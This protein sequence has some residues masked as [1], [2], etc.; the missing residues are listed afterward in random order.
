MNLKEVYCF[1]KFKKH[2]DLFLDL[3]DQQCQNLHQFLELKKIDIKVL[4]IDWFFTLGFSKI[5]LEI[6]ST[7]IKN[8][9]AEGWF[10]FYA[11]LIAFLKK[12]CNKTNPMNDV[13]EDIDGFILLSKIKNFHKQP[14]FPWLE[15]MEEAKL[16]E[17]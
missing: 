3:I 11:F 2:S 17:F 4:I 10:F 7:F 16:F 8:L 5:P 13:N 6:S 9:I 15:I 12:F 14:E 1:D